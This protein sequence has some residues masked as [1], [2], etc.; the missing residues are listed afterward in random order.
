M[1]KQLFKLMAECNKF[2]FPSFTKKRL[3]L[4]KANKVQF[5]II[6][7]RTFITKNAL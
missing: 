7:W 5:A 6:A 4:G 2:I 1:E 3:D